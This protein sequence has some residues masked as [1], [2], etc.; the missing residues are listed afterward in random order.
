MS[1]RP[2][3]TEIG[4]AR[5][6]SHAAAA[7]SSSRYQGSRPYARPSLGVQW[8][9]RISARASAPALLLSGQRMPGA[10]QTAHAAGTPEQPGLTSCNW[11]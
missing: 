1:V 6:L 10:E 8:T 5:A 4:F 11:C 2:G 7:F 3:C 9:G